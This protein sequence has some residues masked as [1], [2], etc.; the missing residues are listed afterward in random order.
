MCSVSLA[1]YLQY[2]GIGELPVSPLLD[3]TLLM[4]QI[5]SIYTAV[6]LPNNCLATTNIR[7]LGPG[8]TAVLK[9]CEL[10]S[11]VEL[12]DLTFNWKRIGTHNGDEKLMDIQLEGQSRISINHNGWLI[13]ENV[14]Q[15]DLGVYK[16]NISNEMGYAVNTVLLELVEATSSPASMPQAQ[17]HILSQLGR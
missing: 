13:I 6:P 11:P 10:T 16:V 15:S 5:L 8:T 2:F 14:Q 3:R 7:V 17:T 1:C 9:Y 4:I 12:S